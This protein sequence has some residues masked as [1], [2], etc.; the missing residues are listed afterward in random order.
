[1]PVAIVLINTE[2]GSETDVL[3]ALA[4]IDGVKEV[5]EVYG[6]YD[7]VAKIEATTHEGLRDLII[8]RIR[9]IPQVRGT[10]TMIVVEQR[11]VR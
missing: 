8:N 6:M 3:N 10:T 11:I 7:I 4:N 1:M 5:Y 9:K 2:I